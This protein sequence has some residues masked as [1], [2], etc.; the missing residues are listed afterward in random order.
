MKSWLFSK[1]S[2][3]LKIVISL[4]LILLIGYNM[5]TPSFKEKIDN[6]IYT[7]SINQLQTHHVKLKTETPTFTSTGFI[8][9][10]NK[11]EIISQVS[12]TINDPDHQFKVGQ[13]I[14]KGDTIIE[15]KDD[16]VRFQLYARK[17]EFI[18]SLTQLI[19][20]YSIDFPQ[21]LARWQ[22][23]LTTFQIE[24]TIDP[25]PKPST[26]KETYY[27]SA[28]NIYSQYYAIKQLEHQ[29]SKY[30]LNAD[31]DGIIQQPNISHLDTIIAGQ[32]IGQFLQPHDYEITFS[33]SQA[34]QKL[35]N[36][37]NTI[38][39]QA[40]GHVETTSIQSISAGITAT[41]QTIEVY[42]TFQSKIFKDGLIATVRIVGNP[43]AQVDRLPCY[44]I[45]NDQTVYINNNNELKKHPI[46]IILA[47]QETCIVSGLKNEQQVITSKTIPSNLIPNS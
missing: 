44:I 39:I 45:N 3:P 31:F 4:S 15:I 26:Q 27:L 12:G 22:R 1:Q 29:L 42:A 35:I 47:Q 7:Q 14:K 16:E 23:Y 21:Q 28:K 6:S 19:S 25:L 37:G 24:S 40:N 46:S 30:K 32:K 36:V 9:A 38:E 18:K 11:M 5:Y 2:L 43:I 17:S 33:V 20:D 13:P 8:T 10:R 41:S 34:F